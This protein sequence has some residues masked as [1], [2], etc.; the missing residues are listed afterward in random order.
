MALAGLGLRAPPVGWLSVQRPLTD[1]LSSQLGQSPA[2]RLRV[3]TQADRR[4][5]QPALGPILIMLSISLYGSAGIGPEA[6]QESVIVLSGCGKWRDE[7]EG[8]MMAQ[9][10]GWPQVHSEAAHYQ[11][12]A[13][14]PTSIAPKP[15]CKTTGRKDSP[16]TVLV[17]RLEDAKISRACDPPS[18]I[19][20]VVA[21]SVDRPVLVWETEGR[22]DV[23]AHVREHCVFDGD[24]LH[25][26]AHLTWVQREPSK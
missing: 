14:T 4:K 7:L 11:L 20:H 26:P 23:R 1:R 19:L 9:C 10:Q 17:S 21:F 8:G 12:H 13:Q 5:N 24:S 2:C 15:Q 3:G 25:L 6:V 22:L 18:W 16:P